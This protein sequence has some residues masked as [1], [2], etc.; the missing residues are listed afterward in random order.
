MRSKKV[1][2]TKWKIWS[3][4]V[5][6]LFSFPSEQKARFTSSGLI[7]QWEITGVPTKTIRQQIISPKSISSVSILS[8]LNHELFSVEAHLDLDSCDCF[9]VVLGVQMEDQ[10][11]K[12]QF[13]TALTFINLSSPDT[14]SRHASDNY[15]EKVLDHSQISLYPHPFLDTSLQ[16]SPMGAFI[17]WLLFTSV[18]TAPIT[19]LPHAMLPSHGASGPLIRMDFWVKE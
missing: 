1:F 5:V 18:S 10:W 12:C 4:L 9:P 19:D 13:L 17:T 14:T 2:K 8:R 16:Y 6:F 15:E 3:K 11:G 7:P